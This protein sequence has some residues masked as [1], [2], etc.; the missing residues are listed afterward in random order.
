[1]D[2]KIRLDAEI[3]KTRNMINKIKDLGFDT[4]EYELV[5]SEILKL[6]DN[7]NNSLISLKEARYQEILNNIYKLQA[8]LRR[9]SNFFK[10]FKAINLIEHS[11]LDGLSEGELDDHINKIIE[12]LNLIHNWKIVSDSNR[13]MVINKFYEV[14]Y[15]LVKLELITKNDSI[16][17]DE[18]KNN[19]IDLIYLDNI[20]REELNNNSELS[21]N[22]LI[23]ERYLF[24]ESNGLEQHFV[25]KGLIR[26]IAIYQDKKNDNTIIKTNL[27]EC[28]HDITSKANKVKELKEDIASN[29][30]EITEACNKVRE[31][32]GVVIKRISSFLVTMTLL[33]TGFVYAHKSYS[34]S[35]QVKHYNTTIES[36]DSSIDSYSKN[37]EYRIAED[38][39][40][41]VEVKVYDQMPKKQFLSNDY[42]GYYTLYSL[43]SEVLKNYSLEDLINLY[44]TSKDEFYK[45]I[46][47]NNGQVT[48]GTNTLTNNQ[49][50]S[51]G[52][53]NIFA[54]LD[55]VLLN[56]ETKG[57]Y[58]EAEKTGQYNLDD[59]E[60]TVD[61]GGFVLI[62][63][64]ALIGLAVS[65][66]ILSEEFD[67]GIIKN[68]Y[69]LFKD[70]L[71]F[72]QTSKTTKKELLRKKEQLLKELNL[73]M[74]ENNELFEK[75]QNE[76]QPYYELLKHDEDIKEM[77]QN[78]KRLT[79]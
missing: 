7:D 27:I 35:N 31:C 40:G 6:K 45:F 64:A 38:N 53:K 62:I 24:L 3:L 12:I 57:Y 10:T 75:F 23:K 65:E 58:I 44:H 61:Y 30:K 50:Y 69:Y 43:T 78:V 21:N 52:Y 66:C 77:V 41:H 42:D 48:E 14:F 46:I 76:Y 26:L 9:E 47:N 71:K 11:L 1:M 63:F 8:D 60:T 13:N 28:H 67:K 20:I 2:N 4:N 39:Y 37:S 79:R 51:E 5:L 17:L 73:I 32:K 34:E 55:K 29:E 19:D 15:Q 25:D 16:L 49:R 72:Y 18:I 36:Y 56:M 54:I 22:Q 74:S 70:D 33:G 59:Y 68:L